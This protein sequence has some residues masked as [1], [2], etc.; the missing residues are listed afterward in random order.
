MPSDA[1]DAPM[2]DRR[3]HYQVLGVDRGAPADELRAAYL[4]QARRFHPDVVGG[5]LADISE[6][7]REMTMVNRAWEV[8][9]DDSAR[10]RYDRTLPAPPEPARPH[11]ESSLNGER[12]DELSDFADTDHLDSVTGGRPIVGVARIVLR[13]AP[14]SFVVGLVVV[15][16][17]AAL[18]VSGIW[19]LGLATLLIS[20]V[21]FLL[22]PFLVM[23]S[24]AR[25]P[26]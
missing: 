1:Y 16:L 18:Q 7:E 26:R 15:I 8:L 21:S 22:A 12:F 13:L 19:N 24:S 10:R 9:G 5:D 14:L 20:M 2:A 4:R 3:T 6:A 25:R 23:S 17:G 11:Q